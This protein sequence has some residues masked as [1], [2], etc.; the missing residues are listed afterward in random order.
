MSHCLANPAS[1][2][3][4]LL[5]Y[6]TTETKRYDFEARNTQEAA[7]IVREIKKGVSPYNKDIYGS[8]R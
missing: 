1:S 5:V 4:Q 6:K 7:E 2:P 3:A 8:P